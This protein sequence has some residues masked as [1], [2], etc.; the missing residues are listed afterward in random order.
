MAFYNRYAQPPSTQIAS[1]TEFPGR[2]SLLLAKFSILTQ[3]IDTG[4]TGFHWVIIL[5]RPP[6]PNV[7][8]AVPNPHSARGRGP[9]AQSTSA[10]LFAL[11]HLLQARSGSVRR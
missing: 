10:F 2:V 11:D 5:A 4:D 7:S 6:G 3:A 9:V 1:S 8:I